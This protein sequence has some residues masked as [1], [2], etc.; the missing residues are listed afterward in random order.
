MTAISSTRSPARSGVKTSRGRPRCP[1]RSGTSGHGPPCRPTPRRHARSS[2]SFATPQRVPG[3]GQPRSGRCR[4]ERAR[5]TAAAARRG[6][7]V[8]QAARRRRQG[9]LPGRPQL[10]PA[11]RASRTRRRRRR[12]GAQR[13]L[14]P[15]DLD[16]RWLRTLSGRSGGADRQPGLTVGRGLDI[17][18]PAR[19][20]PPCLLARAR[21]PAST[22]SPAGT[23][24]PVDGHD[25]QPSEPGEPAEC[26]A[27][28]ERQP[29]GGE[30]G[31]PSAHPDRGGELAWCSTR[32]RAWASGRGRPARRC[33]SCRRW[34]RRR[35]RRH[36]PNAVP[37]GSSWTRPWSTHSQMKPPCRPGVGLDRLPVLLQRP[38]AVAHGMRVLAHDQ[39]VPLAARRVADHRRD[40]RVHRAGQVAHGR[41]PPSPT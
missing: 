16:G 25:D 1:S 39:G 3:A 24:D 27:V 6:A 13:E 28:G 11:P 9:G 40:R 36:R 14:G 18:A 30:I 21:A 35:S 20:Q 23:V 34:A 41:S 5:G 31:R 7:S 4:S 8:D 38:V 22:T 33:R 37:S 29:A 17:G 10:P 26:A 15:A 12:H 19:P 32:G 2:S